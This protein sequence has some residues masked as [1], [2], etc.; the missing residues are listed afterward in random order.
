[1]RSVT[2]QKDPLIKLVRDIQNVEGRVEH[3]CYFA[4]GEELV[5]RAF[6]YGGTV[7]YLLMTDKYADT[8][9]GAY[10]QQLASERHVDSYICSSGLLS[11]ILDAKPVPECLAVVDR[12]LIDT[13]Q[14]FNGEGFVFAIESCENSDNLGMLLRCG[15]A[16][17]AGAVVL[18][19]NSV[20]PFNRKTVRG[21]R[22]AVFTVP[23]C[24][25]PDPQVLLNIAHSSG[26]RVVSSS[27]NCNTL[28]T[29]ADMTGKVVIVVGNEH[30]GISDTMRNGSDAV[31]RI[32]MFGR[33]NS[34]N[35]A[36]AASVLMYECI[37]Q[38]SI[39]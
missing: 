18:T 26:Y 1:M 14:A 39:A 22:G 35:I 31:V 20:E 7:R 29:D 11:K 24:I 2:G 36:T 5:K 16:A 17:G 8:D 28:Y 23:L 32:P 25:E 33:I 12:I 19:G 37:R 3:S 21:S 30:T 27:A 10:L 9:T 38:S 15:D 4:E 34:L 6:E 13:R